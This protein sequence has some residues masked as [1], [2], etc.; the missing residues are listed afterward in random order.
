MLSKTFTAKTNDRQHPELRFVITGRVEKTVTLIPKMIKLRGSADKE[1]KATLR[2]IPEKKYPFEITTTNTRKKDYITYKLKKNKTSEGIEYLLTVTN[3]KK[4]K[5]RFLD[6]IYLNTTNP[7]I[8]KI[9]IKVQGNILASK[10]KR[11]K[12]GTDK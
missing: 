1:I 5:G 11:L 4:E 2:I 12:T 10:E 7:I 8:P 9:V 6:T 3:Q